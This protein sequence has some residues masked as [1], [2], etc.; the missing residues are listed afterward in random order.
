MSLV[1]AGLLAS[2]ALS[3]FP[4]PSKKGETG[5]RAVQTPV[6]DFSLVDQ[7]GNPFRF[8]SSRGKIVLLTFVYTACPDVCPLLAAKFASIRSSGQAGHEL[9][10]DEKLIDKIPHG[11]GCQKQKG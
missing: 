3:H 5:R 4:I 2:P 10:T 11:Q 9:Y 8:E 7:E 6:P 1:I